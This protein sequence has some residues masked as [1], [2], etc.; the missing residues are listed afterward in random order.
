MAITVSCDWYITGPPRWTKGGA[1]HPIS[2]IVTPNIRPI[3]ECCPVTPIY[4]TNG[5]RSQDL[6]YLV[7][8]EFGG[9]MWTTYKKKTHS[10][11]SSL[12]ISTVHWPLCYIIRW[13]VQEYLLK[14]VG[15]SMRIWQSAWDLVSTGFLI[16]K[17]R[18]VL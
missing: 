18:D 7:G 5:C 13:P 3:T 2:H 15:K 1:L 11:L 17:L 8:R 10:S 6:C 14:R 12:R 4:Y 16:L 9:C